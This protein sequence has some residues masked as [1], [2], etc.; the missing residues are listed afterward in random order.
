M[1]VEHEVEKGEVV[2]PLKKHWKSCES[3][4]GKRGQRCTKKLVVAMAVDLCG[5]ENGE[6]DQLPTAFPLL[7]LP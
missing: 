1:L 2:R 3:G 6:K 4:P 5:A 7:A